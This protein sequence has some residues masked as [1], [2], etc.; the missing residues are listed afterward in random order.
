MAR[1]NK[2]IV[3][4]GYIT[5]E[6]LAQVFSHASLF[7]LP[8]YHEGLPIALLEALSFG[9]PVL[10]SDIPAHREVGLPEERYF[11][12]GNVADLSRKLRLLIDRNWT[13]AEKEAL[14]RQ[15]QEK[16]DWR[17]IAEQTIA[18]YMKAVGG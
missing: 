3:L 10:V 15:I 7:V 14:K 17:R 6:A 4:T 8:S 11:R 18:V 9:L 13:F 12:C 16:Y 1:E 2:Q 5:G